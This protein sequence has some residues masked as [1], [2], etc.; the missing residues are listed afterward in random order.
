MDGGGKLDAFLLF[1]AESLLKNTEEATEARNSKGHATEL[2]QHNVPRFD[3]N[4]LF[5]TG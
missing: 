5:G 2:T 4:A 3:T 1:V